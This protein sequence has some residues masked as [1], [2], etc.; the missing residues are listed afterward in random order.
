MVRDAS[1]SPAGNAKGVSV[2]HGDGS[3]TSEGFAY[4][5]KTLVEIGGKR[6]RV[7]RPHIEPN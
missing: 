5:F 7:L 4:L 3:F 6:F 1:L 2:F